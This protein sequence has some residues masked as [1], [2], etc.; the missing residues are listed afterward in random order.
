MSTLIEAIVFF[1]IGFIA[2][3]VLF[4]VIFEDDL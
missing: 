2:C 3:I 1:I 4:A